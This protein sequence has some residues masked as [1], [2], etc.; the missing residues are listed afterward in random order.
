MLHFHRAH[1]IDAWIQATLVQEDE[2]FLLGS[3]MQLLHVGGNIGGSGEMTAN[4][5]A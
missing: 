3:I 4:L 5:E 2:S 1:D